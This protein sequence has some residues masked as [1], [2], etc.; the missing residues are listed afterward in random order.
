RTSR[1]QS[2]HEPPAGTPTTKASSRTCAAS[3]G[4]RQHRRRHRPPPAAADNRRGEPRTAAP[5]RSAP[6]PHSHPRR[7]DAAG[8]G[9]APAAALGEMRRVTKPGG[10]V[11]VADEQPWL[12]R[13][14]LGH[15]IG[16]PRIDAA[17]LQLL[18][19]DPEFI[20]MVFT[21]PQDLG[22]I[23]EEALPA[24]ERHRIWR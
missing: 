18:G 2:G 20:E 24:I 3:Q 12:C 9:L 16:L 6:P 13:M 4:H 1:K 14:G 10:P 17:W 7:P 5:A 21:L 22:P 11:I 8:P 19:L 15:L 23:A